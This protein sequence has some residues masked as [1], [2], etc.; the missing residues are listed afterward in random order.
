MASLYKTAAAVCLV[1]LYGLQSE[2]A[3][4]TIAYKFK[5][6]NVD[7]DAYMAANLVRNGRLAVHISE[8]AKDESLVTGLQKKVEPNKDLEQR[9]VTPEDSCK[10]VMEN[11]GLKDIF[12]HAFTYKASNNYR[13]LFQE[14]LDA[15][16]KVFKPKG[17][18]GNWEEIWTDDDG[19]NLAYLLGSNST[20][21]GCVIGQCIKVE[22]DNTGGRISTEEQTGE[23]F[24]F[25]E[26]SPAAEENKAP[27]DE[28]YFKGLITRTA[29]LAEMTE[30]DLKA[31]TNDGTA[32][33]AV[34]TILAASLV[35][36]VTAISV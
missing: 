1:A 30:E 11:A 35:A 24:L 21:M 18:Q 36:M 17:Y 34:P 23:D 15:G 6:L 3:D 7:D 27:F 4:K 25:C 8:V 5:A 32:A 9:D 29:K 22:T 31:S 20:K 2:A 19:A 13:E 10:K 12:H 28:E 33:T 14:A 16:L 26:L